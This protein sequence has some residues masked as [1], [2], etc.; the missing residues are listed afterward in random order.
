MRFHGKVGIVQITLKK[1]T[2]MILF[3]VGIIEMTI[4]TCWTRTVSKAEVATTGFVTAINIIIWYFVINEIVKNL[5]NWNAIIPYTA[6]CVIGSM[7][8]VADHAK[9]FRRVK[10]LFAKNKKD[11][12]TAPHLTTSTILS[13][14]INS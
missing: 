13:G 4:A 11:T 3:F 5:N 12:I 2:L 7:F 1:G 14:K 10:K 6:G 8:G 9:M